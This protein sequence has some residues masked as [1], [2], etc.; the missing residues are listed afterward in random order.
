ME[1]MEIGLFDPGMTPLHRAGLAGLYMTLSAFDSAG[2][3]ITGLDWELKRRKLILHWDEDERRPAF[4]QLVENAFRIDQEGFFD[5]PA[6]QRNVAQDRSQKRHLHCVLLN[7]FFQHGQHRTLGEAEDFSYEIDGKVRWISNF[8]P[9]QELDCHQRFINKLS[10]QKSGE[11]A[12]Q[13]IRV[14][15]WLY[16]GAGQRHHRFTSTKLQEPLWRSLCLLFAP[17]GCLYYRIRIPDSDVNRKYRVALIIPRVSDLKSYAQLRESGAQVHV[18]EKVAAGSSDAGLRFVFLL[19]QQTRT[20]QM[21]HAVNSE[22]P[23]GVATFGSVQWNKNQKSRTHLF[24]PQSSLLDR[25]NGRYNYWT[26]YRCFPNERLRE[27]DPDTGRE[28][29]Q[30]RP[31]AA[32]GLVADNVASGKPWYSGFAD[33]MSQEQFRNKLFYER[34]G[35]HDMVEQSHFD[36][37]RERIFVKACHQAWRSRMAQ[38]YERAKKENIASE[39]LINRERERFRVALTRCKNADTLRETVT[40]FWARAGT[41]SEL[42]EHWPEMLPLLNEDNWR[43]ARDL[44]MLALASYPSETETE[45]SNSRPEQEGVER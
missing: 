9:V 45:S 33:M 26:A 35:L 11:W 14:A 5:F 36:Q 32:R 44:A 23:C 1:V 12:D 10:N 43:K 18:D 22:R 40:D 38:L 34:R 27:T 20:D 28:Y 7:T 13:Q 31:S 21:A 37:E 42:G 8:Q 19:D 3:T 2:S 41:I 24:T 29:V 25:R 39:P 15:G 16:P 17:I 30:V 6:L 4:E